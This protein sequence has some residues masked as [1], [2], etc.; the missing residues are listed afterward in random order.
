M[1]LYGASSGPAPAFDPSILAVRGSL[2]LTRPSLAHYSMSRDEILE[3]TSDLF[4]WLGNRELKFKVDHV[5]P[6]AEAG[7]AHAALAGR[8]TPGKVGLVP[9]GYGV[10]P[11]I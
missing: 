5:F 2:F 11:R 8:H 4:R 9:E 3:R 6:L 1:V 7:K 10:P